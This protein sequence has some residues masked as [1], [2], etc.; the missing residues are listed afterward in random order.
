M[1]ALP[2]SGT[3]RIRGMA[4]VVAVGASVVFMAAPPVPGAAISSA[5]HAQNAPQWF[6]FADVVDKIKPAV[7]S[8]R[9]TPE[10]GARAGKGTPPVPDESPLERFFRRFGQ[11]DDE[12]A[13]ALRGQ[14]TRQGAG[15]FIS[16]DGYAV[17]NNHVVDG[18]KTVEVTTDREILGADP[19]RR[20]L[21]ARSRQPLRARRHR[22]RRHRVGART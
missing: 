4:G 5:A 9:T 12:T 14:L 1:I 7:I 21:G 6:G 3:G 2:K 20:R 13:P 8:V 22:D 16:P 15:F 11:P 10:A 17:T 19:A 18:V